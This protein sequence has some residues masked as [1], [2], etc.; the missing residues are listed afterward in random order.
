MRKSLL[1]LLTVA[2]T[3]FSQP[4]P[5]NN[6]SSDLISLAHQVFDKFINYTFD[7][8]LY[9]KPPQE[10]F[11]DISA[12]LHEQGGNLSDA[13]INKVITTLKCTN[14]YNVNHN[15]ILTVIDYSLPSREKRLWIFDLKQKKLLFHTYVSHG[16]KSG[17]L[18]SSFFS[19][20]YDSK[21]S[22]IGVYKTEQTY[23]GRDGLSLRLSGLERG[24]NDNAMNRYIVMHGGWYVDEGFIKRYG[25]A[26]RSWGCPAVPEYL[27]KD[28]INTIK[29]HSLFVVYYPSDNW[30]AKSRFLN[31]NKL[32]DNQNN[33]GLLSDP[34]TVAIEEHRD[35]IVFTD[36]NKNSRREENESIIVM[37]ADNYE[38]AFKRRA[39]LER[40]LRRQINHSEYIA[41]STVELEHLVSA[42][43]DS[44]RDLH[45]VIPVIK[46]NR[47]YYETE[48]HFVPLGKIKEVR[49]NQPS[50]AS[51]NKPGNYTVLLEGKPVINLKSTNQFI[52]WL[53]L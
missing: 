6:Q 2:S 41:L 30:F 48:M 24:F 25:R 14:Q 42:N 51:E 10:P 34:S 16:I 52:R 4:A 26:G 5:E 22:S 45:F 47:G 7:E 53:G 37:A 23:Y 33:N 21:A 39:P 49:L 20:K 40:M 1:L 29:D 28:I 12:M 35:Y 13:V 36:M 44:L 3:C 32:A 50:S 27:T 31:C 9:V 19:N 43:N 17:A 46:L 15:N 18:L 11:S 38:Q 8:Y